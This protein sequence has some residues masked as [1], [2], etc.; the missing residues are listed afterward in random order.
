MNIKVK[1]S[2]NSIL[3]EKVI[4]ELD[5]LFNLTPPATLRQSL[6]EIFFSYLCNTK[7][8]DHKPELKD[9]AADFYFLIKFLDE[10]EK[11]KSHE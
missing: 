3:N 6:T 7:S 1:L 11:E 4:Q 10:V 2:Q 9:I 8:E 5:D